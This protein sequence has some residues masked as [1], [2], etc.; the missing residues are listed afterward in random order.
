MSRTQQPRK[1]RRQPQRGDGLVDLHFKASKAL[2]PGAVGVYAILSLD[3]DTATVGIPAYAAAATAYFDMY[4]YFRIK[5]VTVQVAL[6]ADPTATTYSGVI[7]HIAPGATSAPTTSN[8]FETTNQVL[9]TSHPAHFGKLALTQRD[10]SGVGSWCVTQSDATDAILKSFGIIY[11]AIPVPYLSTYF[12]DIL[13]HIDCHL[14]FKTLLDPSTIS[15]NFLS[16]SHKTDQNLP[17]T[18][19]YSIERTTP[20]MPDLSNGSHVRGC[21]CNTCVVD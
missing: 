6:N 3:S 4:R 13:V 2:T 10:L 20:L 21:R 8:D 9:T 5:R 11:L 14:E 17:V 15:L 16:P 1:G 18:P 12:P 7:A 19:G